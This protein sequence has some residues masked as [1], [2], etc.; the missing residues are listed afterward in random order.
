MTKIKHS[1]L[2]RIFSA[3]LAILLAIS[4]LGATAFAAEPRTTVY[5]SDDTMDYVTGTRTYYFTVPGEYDPN[6]PTYL[7]TTYQISYF[8]EDRDH[9]ENGLLKFENLTDSDF[10]D[11]PVDFYEMVAPAHAEVNLIQGCRYKVTFSPDCG[12]YYMMNFNMYLR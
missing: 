1:Y 4:S 5:L 6:E 12:G 11:I 9:S 3:C 8:Y 10:G 2:F 7:T